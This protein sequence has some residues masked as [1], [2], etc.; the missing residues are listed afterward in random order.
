MR[1]GEGKMAS[2]PRLE[3]GFREEMM[4]GRVQ[5][6][7]DATLAT[8]SMAAGNCRA[9]LGQGV[10]ASKETVWAKFGPA[11]VCLTPGDGYLDF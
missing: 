7:V 6:G 2:V 5:V 3:E 10:M 8:S 4:G 1:A 11:V 9:S